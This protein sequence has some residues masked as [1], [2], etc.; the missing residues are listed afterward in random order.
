MGDT[1]LEKLKAGTSNQK[2]IKWPGTECNVSIRVLNEQDQIEATMA[3]DAI[4]TAA[5]V[6]VSFEN[7]DAYDAEKNNQL[8]F[9]ALMDPLTKKPITS[10]M[11]QFRQL[12]STG[13]RAVLIDEVFSWQEECS[14]SPDLAPDKYDTLLEAV[15]KNAEA[16]F[17]MPLN[18]SLAKRLIRSLV[19]EVCSLQTANGSI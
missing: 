15:K 8:L 16:V 5:N 6:K 4:Y 18:I 17:M 2:V 1:L 19:A 11:E 13:V 9:R 12:L 10:T 14:P 3:T 7:S